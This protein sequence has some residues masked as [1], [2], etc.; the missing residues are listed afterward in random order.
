MFLR[1]V[2]GLLYASG[3]IFVILSVLTLI[4]LVLIHLNG[5]VA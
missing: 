2:K 5:G 3:V 4:G 1:V